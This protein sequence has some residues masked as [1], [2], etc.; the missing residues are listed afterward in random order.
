MRKGWVKYLQMHNTRGPK[1]WKK[2]IY[3]EY[4]DKIEIVSIGVALTLTEIDEEV[5]FE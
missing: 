3:D 1:Q 2:R 5:D 4:E